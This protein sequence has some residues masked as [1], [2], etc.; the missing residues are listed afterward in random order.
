LNINNLKVGQVIPNY[1]KLCKLLNI[2]I[3]AGGSSKIAQLKEMSRYLKYHKEGN[4]FI[5]DEIYDTLL[6]KIDG[7]GSNQGGGHNRKDF[8]A[9]LISLEDENKIGVYKI[10]LNNDIYI[11]STIVGFRHRFLSHN[12]INCNS[13]PFTYQML[14][15]GATFD[16]IKICEGLTEPEIRKIENRFIEEY[17]NNSEW[18]VI[19]SKSA[20]SYTEP[21]QRYKNINIKVKAEDH[22]ST[23][24]LLKEL[25]LI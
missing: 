7:R 19:N 6:D 21:K 4:K 14:Q 18:N 15:D 25:N 24:K 16:I 11:G 17:K 9:F 23:L 2:N 3:T 13:V 5:I 12:N 20:W 1:R 8:P 22:K 10:T